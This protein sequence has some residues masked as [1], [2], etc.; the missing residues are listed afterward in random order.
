MSR[1]SQNR[2]KQNQGKTTQNRLII[3]TLVAGVLL[4]AIA[5]V[6][7]FTDNGQ[8]TTRIADAPAD[9]HS[10][11]GLPY[12][13]VAR[14][15]VEEALAKVESGEALIVDVRDEAAYTA[16]HIAGAMSLPEEALAARGNE[17][18]EDQLIITYCT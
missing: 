5:L 11:D 8:A 13:A 1:R 2:R 9:E 10:E 15:S 4:I 16:S 18:P 14:I 12:P 3:G 7:T 17:L 6:I